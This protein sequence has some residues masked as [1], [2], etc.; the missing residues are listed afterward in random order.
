M[1]RFIEGE[2]RSQSTLFPESLED[3]IAQD[4]AI[5]VVDAFVDKLDL[6]KLGFDRAEPSV[7]GRPGYQP[8]TMLKIYVYG[9]L[10]RIQSSRRPLREA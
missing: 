6:K 2:N 1:K 7:T 10:N 4:N 8:A 3:H 9:Y 5:R